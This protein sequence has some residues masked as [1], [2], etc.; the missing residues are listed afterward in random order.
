MALCSQP[1]QQAGAVCACMAAA[2][3]EPCSV[4][5]RTLPTSKRWQGAAFFEESS[6]S[7]SIHFGDWY[8]TCICMAQQR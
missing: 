5:I 7:S 4:L 8:S 1:E 3:F 2:C 6:S